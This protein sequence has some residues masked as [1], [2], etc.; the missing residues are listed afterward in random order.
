MNKKYTAEEIAQIN[1][2]YT[3][4]TPRGPNEFNDWMLKLKSAYY[5]NNEEMLNAFDKFNEEE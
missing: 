2:K 3:E 1:V 4:I 5:S